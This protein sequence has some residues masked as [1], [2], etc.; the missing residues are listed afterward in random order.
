M[1]IYPAFYALIA[2]DLRRVLAHSLNSQLGFMVVGIGIGTAQAMNGVIAHA[3]ASVIYQA[4]LFMAMGWVMIST[5]M[6]KAHQ[7]ASLERPLYL[8]M[9]WTCLFSLIGAMS[10]IGMP[11]FSGYVTK[12]MVVDASKNLPSLMIWGSLLFANILAIYHSAIR[13]HLIAFFSG[14]RR[15]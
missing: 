5:K 8:S 3:F 9:P 14:G 10:L 12:T 11:F 15:M 1:A 6:I 4:L 13:L 7:L 2:N